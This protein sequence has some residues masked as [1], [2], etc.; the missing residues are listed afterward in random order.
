MKVMLR[1]ILELYRPVAVPR[2]RAVR[3]SRARS[4]AA[5]AAAPCGAK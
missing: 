3:A 1:V 2:G 4:P 5:A